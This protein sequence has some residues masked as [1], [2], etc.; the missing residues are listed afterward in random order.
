ML[1]DDRDWIGMGI[2]WAGDLDPNSM[3]TVLRWIIDWAAFRPEF[4]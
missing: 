4:N 3:R 2:D 1:N